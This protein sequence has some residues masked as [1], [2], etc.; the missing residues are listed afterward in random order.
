MRLKLLLIIPAVLSLT[1]AQ[2]L[3]TNGDFEQDLTAGWTQTKGGTGTQTMDRS[4]GYHP[5]PDCEAMAYQ[6][7]GSGWVKLAQTL[8]MPGPD[9]LLTFWASFWRGASSSACWPVA[10]VNASYLDAGGTL[11]GE[12]RFYYHDAY[13]TWTRSSTLNLI[14]VTDPNW[15]QYSLD[16]RAEIATNLPGVNPDNV[17]KIQVALYVYTSGG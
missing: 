9:A 7:S 14:D 2:N 17:R 11:L 6:Y 5:D 15:T 10:C 8:D 13:C 3:L 16:V 1:L 4:V 12:T